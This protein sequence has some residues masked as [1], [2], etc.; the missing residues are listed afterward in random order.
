MLEHATESLAASMVNEECLP[1]IGALHA[2][3]SVLLAESPDESDVAALRC[4]LLHCDI[5][6]RLREALS[7]RGGIGKVLANCTEDKRPASKVRVEVRE[8]AG[9]QMTH[10]FTVGA[11]PE[12]YVQVLGDPTVEP[13]QCLV[14]PLPGGI[15]VTDAW[16]NGRTCVTWRQKSGKVVSPCA[17]P[18]CR[19]A[20][21]IGHG[22]RALLSLGTKTT[23]TLGPSKGEIERAV[24]AEAFKS[25][26]SD[27]LQ[28]VTTRGSALSRRSTSASQSDDCGDERPR[29]K[30][31]LQRYLQFRSV[32][33][34]LF[35]DQFKDF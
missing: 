16:S 26:E 22:E 3:Q 15:V 24:F 12:C 34:D 28:T 17:S 19:I 32:P 20:F 10:A 1:G 30:L 6:V 13:L 31:K 21:T 2:L 4:S 7:Q 33:E 8:S 18:A 9:R 5:V 25:G 23:I 11:A 35:E 29:K 14:I 27:H